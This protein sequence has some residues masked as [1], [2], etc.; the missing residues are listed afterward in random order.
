[1]AWT[2]VGIVTLSTEW[3]FVPETESKILRLRVVRSQ[4]GISFSQRG[5]LARAVQSDGEWQ[6][7]GSKR[8]Y[9]EVDSIILDFRDEP[10]EM[11]GAV[12]ALRCPKWTRQPWSIFIDVPDSYSETAPPQLPRVQCDGESDWLII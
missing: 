5:Y 7:W 2:Q 4:D 10:I 12:L 11:A 8:L 1:M 9:M 3:Q 6:F